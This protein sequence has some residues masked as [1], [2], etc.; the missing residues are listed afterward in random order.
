MPLPSLIEIE[1]PRE[2]LAAPAPAP[3]APET[4]TARPPQAGAESAIRIADAPGTPK[5]LMAGV[6]GHKGPDDGS[7]P[8]I[9]PDTPPK[10]LATPANAARAEPL[11]LAATR[12]DFVALPTSE[13]VSAT[14]AAPATTDPIDAAD[15]L[16][17]AAS[18]SK[19]PDPETKETPET[20]SYSDKWVLT[21]SDESYVIQVFGARDRAA[22]EAFSAPYSDLRG[23]VAVLAITHQGAPWYVVV[24][25]LY[26]G[27]DAA[28]A[29]I[30]GLSDALQAHG[31]WARSVASLKK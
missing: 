8:A 2:T 13:P 21:Q 4:A 17:Q 18:S 19:E 3:K 28:R 23:R 29:A 1:L 15:P 9:A 5:A 12:H 27:R 22:A 11:E 7:P 6:S 20:N 10:S 24:T 31:P 14:P 26:P 25:G 30:G 16:P